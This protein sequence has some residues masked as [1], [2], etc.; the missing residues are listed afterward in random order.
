[1]KNYPRIKDLREDNDMTQQQIANILGMKQQQYSEY[2]RGKREAP[3]EF[4]IELAK[5]YNVTLDYIAGLIKTPRPLY[6]KEKQIK[7]ITLNQGENI[8]ITQ[9]NN[10]KAI[11]NINK[12]EKKLDKTNKT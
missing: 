5:I 12:H 8:K 9:K 11:V 6:N 10:G 7:E 2:E 3:L 1:M 4:Y